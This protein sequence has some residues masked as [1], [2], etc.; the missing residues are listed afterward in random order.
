MIDFEMWAKRLKNL[1]LE[2]QSKLN[3]L[4]NEKMILQNKKYKN[5]L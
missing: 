1:E 4:E 3:D 2:L 5:F